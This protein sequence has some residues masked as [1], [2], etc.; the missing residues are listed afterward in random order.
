VIDREILF[1][2]TVEDAI[3]IGLTDKKRNQ[4]AAESC[5]KLRIGNIRTIQKISSILTQLRGVL[6]ELGI[7]IPESFDHQLQSTTVLATWAYWERVIDIDALES[8]NIGDSSLVLMDETDAKLSSEQKDLYERVHEYG[9]T[10]SDDTDKAIIRFI[11][12]GAIDKV[13]MRQRV[14]DNDAAMAKRQ[15]DAAMERAWDLYRNTLEENEDHVVQA[16]YQ[17]H[18]DAIEDVGISNL[19][20]AVWVLRGLG[21]EREAEDLMERFFTRSTPIESSQD[22]LFRD[23]VIDEKFKER[24]VDVSGREVV[25]DRDVEATVDSFYHHKASTMHDIKRLAQFTDDQFYDWF[26]NTKYQRAFGVARALAHIEHRPATVITETEQIERN[27]QA[28]LRRLAGESTI[29]RL[30][31]RNLISEA[32]NQRE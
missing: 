10:Y 1:Q 31:L 27:V 4:I 29:N 24:W 30:R 17:S 22:Y 21:R 8:L 6:D 14:L 11:K 16:L 25:D 12:T 9:F 15:R 28:A 18:A 26:K 2:P 3:A 19:S 13:E 5:Q 7:A 20:S 32:Q 23:M